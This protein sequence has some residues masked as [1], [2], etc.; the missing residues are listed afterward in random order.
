MKLHKPPDQIHGVC[1]ECGI[2]ANVLT[3]LKRYGRR[4]DKLCYSVSTSG[5]GI[6]DCCG[7][8]DYKTAV[9]DF[10]HPD[11]SLLEKIWKVNY[12]K[13]PPKT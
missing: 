1:R 13:T 3:C 9:R 8:R 12:V 6:C 11:F 2:S 10:F 7:K 4:P 5:K